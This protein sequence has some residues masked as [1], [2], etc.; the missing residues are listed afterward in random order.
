MNSQ[1]TILEKI[2]EQKKIRVEGAKRGFEYAEFVHRAKTFRKNAVENKFQTAFADRTKTNIIAEIKR[3]SPSRGVIR[4][5]ADAGQIA[6]IYES[7]GASAIS[8]LTEE[9]FFGGN[10][11]DLFAAKNLT[12]LPILRKDFVFD[13]FQVYESALIGADAILL[14]V[15]M[16]DDQTLSHL[17]RL[18]ASLGLDVLV[19]THDDAEF[20]RAVKLG[21][22]IIGVNNRN[23]HTFDVTLDI[24]RRL[25]GSAPK[26]TIMIAESGLTSKVEIDELKVLGFSGFLVGERLMKTENIG[27]TLNSLL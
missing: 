22:K 24:S 27:E 6:H 4:S 19:E 15:A 20:A 23:L 14:I 10:I 11:D 5:D 17:F 21:A 16:L 3:A 1:T 2:F 26:D 18:A 9:D 8:V 13:E 12:D 25:I 7:F